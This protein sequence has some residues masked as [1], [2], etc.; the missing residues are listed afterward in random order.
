MKERE[1]ELASFRVPA[2]A[3]ESWRRSLDH[4]YRWP[5]AAPSPYFETEPQALSADWGRVFD[6]YRY[7][8]DLEGFGRVMTELEE[9]VSDMASGM[10]KPDGTWIPDLAMADKL[11][12]LDVFAADNAAEVRNGILHSTVSA[13]CFSKK[14]TFAVITREGEK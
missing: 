6:Y 8:R 4:T 3:S 5:F 1:P 12:A 13:F 7:Q 14:R 9:S 2:A 10:I 11:I